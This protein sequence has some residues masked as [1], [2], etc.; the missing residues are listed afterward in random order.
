MPREIMMLLMFLDET[1]DSVLFSINNLE[2]F[3]DKVLEKYG[4]LTGE[5]GMEAVQG[6]IDEFLENN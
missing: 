1:P 2:P 5:T 4:E 6:I 3:L